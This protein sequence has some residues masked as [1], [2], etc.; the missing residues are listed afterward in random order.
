MLYAGIDPGKDGALVLLDAEGQI[1]RKHKT[2]LF[3]SAKVKDEYDI[4]GILSL[5]REIKGNPENGNVSFVLEKIHSLPSSMGGSSANYERGL[6]S[7][8]WRTALTAL[9]CSHTLITPQTWQKV[10]LKDQPKIDPKVAAKIV[11]CR[12]WPAETWLRSEQC[13]KPDQGYVDGALLAEFG[14]RTFGGR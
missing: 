11:A 4:G 13:K 3:S 10:M 9:E 12:L 14:R 5:L 6:S 2:P 8:I 1:L 7:G